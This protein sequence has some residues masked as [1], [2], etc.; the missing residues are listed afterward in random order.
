MQQRVDAEVNALVDHFASLVRAA[1]ISD[2][3]RNSQENLQ[4]DVHAART[5][6]AGEALL[7]IIAELK[8]AA[9][10]SDFKHINS[11]VE[12][13]V[14]DFTKQTIHTQNT[15]QTIGKQVEM[16]LHDL[17]KHYY[18]STCKPTAPEP[19]L[20]MCELLQRLEAASVRTAPF[21]APN[22]QH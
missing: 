20:E 3:V 1:R 6:Q 12:Q 13:R 7:D 2:T 16:A 4:I 14:E 21:H 10:L 22:Q 17:E 8:R 18:A 15:L 19:S 5:A 11:S 9:L